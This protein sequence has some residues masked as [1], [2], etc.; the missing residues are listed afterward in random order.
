MNG[1]GIGTDGLPDAGVAVVVLDV[2][3]LH[4]DLKHR[5][6]TTEGQREALHPATVSDGAPAHPV[7]DQRHT[8]PE[9]GMGQVAIRV[10]RL[11]GTDD[12]VGSQ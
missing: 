4:R 1:C 3:G 7:N 9:G 5:L 11:H 2:G 12:G 6:V 8:G 10:E